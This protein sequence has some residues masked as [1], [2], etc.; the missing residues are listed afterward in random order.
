MQMLHS[1]VGFLAKFTS[2]CWFFPNSFFWFCLIYC[3]DIFW[4]NCLKFYSPNYVFLLSTLLFLMPISN[5][6]S[7]I[8]IWTVKTWKHFMW[9][10]KKKLFIKVIKIFASPSEYSSGYISAKYSKLYNS[11]ILISLPFCKK[12]V[13]NEYF[14]NKCQNLFY[15]RKYMP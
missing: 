1:C 8:N 6:F 13:E 4:I 11:N 10:V 15:Q 7:K 5:I 3:S 9:H 12:F 2:Q 14:S